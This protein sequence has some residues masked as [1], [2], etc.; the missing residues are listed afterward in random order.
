MLIKFTIKSETSE[1]NGPFCIYPPKGC[2]SF[3]KIS[4]ICEEKGPQ[5]TV[6]NIKRMISAYQNIAYHFTWKGY[7]YHTGKE[8]KA[9][10]LN[11]TF[12]KGIYKINEQLCLS[13][14]KIL[15][16]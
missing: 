1:T 15:H 9:Q 13:L 16:I 14:I 10:K 12:S 11:T 6:R 4:T 7:F 3:K 5:K 8:N 2:Y